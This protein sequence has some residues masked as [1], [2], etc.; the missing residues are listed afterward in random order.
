MCSVVSSCSMFFSVSGRRAVSHYKFTVTYMWK[1]FVYLKKNV[2]YLQAFFFLQ[3]LLNMKL[4]ILS[5]SQGEVS[6]S[7]S[8]LSW[9]CARYRKSKTPLM[10]YMNVFCLRQ[11]FLHQIPGKNNQAQSVT[12]IKV[13]F[14][15]VH[16]CICSELFWNS[17]LFNIIIYYS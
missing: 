5:K 12:F 6:D 13:L 8:V 4:C 14:H 11:L 10:Q 1:Y 17:T 2:H 16:S 7:D 9:L 3:N 15:F